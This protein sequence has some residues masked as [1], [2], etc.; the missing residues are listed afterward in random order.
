MLSRTSRRIA[1]ATAIGALGVAVALGTTACGA[2]KISQTNN[3]ESAVNGASATLKL[4]DPKQGQPAGSIAIRNLQIVYP[5]DKA[6]DVFG[7]C[8]PFKLV[9]TVANDSVIRTVQLT[10]ITAEQGQVV[11]KSNGTQSAGPGE[12]GK[13]APNGYLTAGVG[14][15]LDPAEAKNDD[16]TRLDVEL[17]G[18][19]DTVAAG[20]STPL[21]LTFDVFDLQGNKVETKS[22]T[23]ATPVDGTPL[24][25]RGDVVREAQPEGDSHH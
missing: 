11:F 10:G 19:G 1:K 21:T 9:F 8:G 13:I 18:A 24:T 25:E 12:S 20:L 16:I 7:D 23:V 17:N 4:S 2:G 14:A 3:K 22:I 6:S 15:L 5:V